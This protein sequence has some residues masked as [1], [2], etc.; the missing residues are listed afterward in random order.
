MDTQKLTEGLRALA[1]SELEWKFALY[2]AGK[3][4][5]GVE[6]EWNQCGMDGLASWVGTVRDSLLKKPVAEKPVADYSPFLSDKENI[7]ALE[8]SD[9]II[10]Q[11]MTDLCVDIRNAPRRAPEDFVSGALSKPTG[12]AFYAE[13]PPALAPASQTT[14][15]SGS[16]SAAPSP[17]P[18]AAQT[19]AAPFAGA[20]LFLRRANPFLTGAS[21]LC[22]GRGGEVAET[23]KPV[24]KLAPSADFLLLNGV[25]YF[26]S[27]GVEKDFELENRHFAIAAKRL[28]TIAEAGLVS[29]MEALEKAAYAPRNA[30]KFA[31]FDKEILGY[32]AR[33]PIVERE[34]FLATFGVTVDSGGKMDTAD[35]EQCELIIDLLCCRSCLDPLGRLSTGSNITVRQ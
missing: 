25:C 2:A 24:L 31:T 11:K 19:T 6:L 13:V 3:S 12:Y 4:R 5:D 27:S 15:F 9:E 22:V 29:D 7:A 10:R 17:I 34:E 8:A 18:S 1:P 33:L 20:V 26:F 35:A 21:R 30:R 14:A 28:A 16:A 32:I 23:D